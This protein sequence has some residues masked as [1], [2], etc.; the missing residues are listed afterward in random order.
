VTRRGFSLLEATVGLALFAVLSLLV[1]AMFTSGVRSTNLVYL[2]HTLQGDLSRSLGRL[3][4]DARRASANLAV[5]SSRQIANLEGNLV[6]RDGLCLPDLKD[7]SAASSY[8]ANA[9]PLWD[10]Y[11]TYYPTTIAPG[12]LM[13]QLY[14]PAGAPYQAPM[15]GFGPA[16]LNDDPTANVGNLQTQVLAEDVEDFLV[17]TDLANQSLLVTI[18]LRKRGGR[19][20]GGSRIQDERLQTSTRIKMGN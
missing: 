10:Q 5:T 7:W 18:L 4:V 9:R 12:R 6:H 8:D 14:R 1:F 16:F 17:T 11:I 13:R 3:Q 20:P 19:A 15:T 2:R